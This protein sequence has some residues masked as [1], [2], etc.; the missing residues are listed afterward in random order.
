M[1][2]DDP[3]FDDDSAQHIKRG[4]VLVPQSDDVSVIKSF[5]S[6]RSRDS[7]GAGYGCSPGPASS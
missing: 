7:A 2:D 1:A 3:S 4:A 5:R 6:P